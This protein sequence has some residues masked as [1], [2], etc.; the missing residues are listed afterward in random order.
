PFAATHTFYFFTNKYVKY[1][2]HSNGIFD[3]EQPLKSYQGA[4]IDFLLRVVEQYINN[5]SFYA[6]TIR[7]ESSKEKDS[8]MVS[9]GMAFPHLLDA[10][11]MQFFILL[12]E[13]KKKVCP[14]CNK[15]FVPERTDKKY[16]SNTCKLT[17]KSRRY[18][19]RQ[20]TKKKII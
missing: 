14:I 9:P 1:K 6:R 15:P 3:N 4:A 8:F 16:C 17:A 2:G 11:Y 13:N 19:E 10:L 5:N 12:N 7:H 20:H 18:R